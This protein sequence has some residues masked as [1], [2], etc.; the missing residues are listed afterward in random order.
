MTTEEMFQ[1]LMNKINS[2]HAELRADIKAEVA[3]LESK[4]DDAIADIKQ[5]K[6]EVHSLW[7]CSE[8]DTISINGAYNGIK[9]VDNKLDKVI[10]DQKLHRRST[11]ATIG[12]LQAQINTLE[13]RLD[14]AS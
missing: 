10:A 6:E 7:I 9:E 11:Q 2:N 3:R 1:M 13:D 14:K 4:I 8:V 5:I 12:E